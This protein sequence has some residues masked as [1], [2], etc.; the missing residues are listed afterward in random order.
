MNK[1][2]TT[3][4]C[5]AGVGAALL[6]AAPTAGADPSTTNNTNDWGQQVKACNAGACEGTNPPSGYPGGENGGAFVSGAAQS[7]PNGFASNLHTST[8]TNGG[9]PP[10]PGNSGGHAQVGTH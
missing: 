5:G 2:V 8:S 3:V 6:L 10:Q 1:K 4:L 7:N 9:N